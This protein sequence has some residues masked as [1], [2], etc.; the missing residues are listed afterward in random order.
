MKQNQE[1]LRDEI[2]IE[3][4]YEEGKK[5]ELENRHAQFIKALDF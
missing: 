3:I 5:R 4:T 1:R 2:E